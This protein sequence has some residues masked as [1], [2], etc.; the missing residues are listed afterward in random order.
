MSWR[1]RIVEHTDD[2][3]TS[4]EVHEEFDMPGG[5]AI[6]ENGI[7]PFGDTKE[8]L[9]ECLEMMLGDCLAQIEEEANA[10]LG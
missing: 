3:V 7:V 6:T 1:Y 10:K 2:D 9:V 5:P 4:Y 8:E